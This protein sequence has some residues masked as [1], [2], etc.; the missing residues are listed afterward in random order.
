M[1]SKSCLPSIIYLQIY[2]VLPVLLSSCSLNVTDD[3]TALSE[4]YSQNFEEHMDNTIG[5]ITSSFGNSKVTGSYSNDGFSILLNDLPEHNHIIIAF[6]LFIHDSWDGNAEY[7]VGP[8]LWR[9]IVNPSDSLSDQSLMFETSF[10]NTGCEP[11]KC[12]Q[13]AFPKAY[14]F[15][16]A[17][18]SGASKLT[19][20][21]CALGYL[22]I[23]TSHYKIE[24]SFFHTGKDLIIRFEDEVVQA[25]S[26]SPK[27]NES[28]SMD[29]I[30]IW[31]ANYR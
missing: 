10:S 14:P 27:C 7:P 24:K 8:D 17:P 3:L 12:F 31:A 16:N 1:F 13:Q 18:R 19:W 4:V 20:G 5:A 11:N 6:D 15:N 25:N 21:R 2:L 22:E 23:G 26:P 28:W 30:V 9:M 29:N